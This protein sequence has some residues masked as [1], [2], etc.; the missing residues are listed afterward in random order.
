MDVSWKRAVGFNFISTLPTPCRRHG[1]SMLTVTA[2]QYELLRME[3][4]VNLLTQAC[5]DLTVHTV[6]VPSERDGWPG[7]VGRKDW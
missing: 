3:R 6:Y 4:E 2:G 5:L 1:V 7:L